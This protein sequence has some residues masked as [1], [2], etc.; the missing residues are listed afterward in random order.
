MDE[1]LD[2]I[3]ILEGTDK[4]SIGHGYLRH[5]DRILG[6]LRHAPITVLEIGVFR[7]AS[8]RMWARYFDQAKIVGVDINPECRQHADDRCDVEIGSQA[9]PQFLDDL[10]RKWQPSVIIDDGSHQA[11]HVILTFRKL[12]PH[13]RDAGIYIVEDLHLHAGPYGYKL[14]GSS[15]VAPGE[16]FLQITGLLS[17]PEETNF[18]DRLLSY[19]MDS[20]E[21]FHGGVAFRKKPVAESDPFSSRRPLVATADK[22]QLWAGFAMYIL[23]RGGDADEA[24]A[25]VRR[26]IDMEPERAGYQHQLSLILQRK[27]DP[28]GALAAAREAVRLDPGFEM[29]QARLAEL[30]AEMA[31]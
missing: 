18:Q 1:T 20:V 21:H 3:G 7:G 8:L 2:A 9:D 16:L 29:F 28:A 12:F 10:G 19:A 4:S 5:Y 11:D 26:A 23:S 31:G 25:C 24:L 27:G 17:C 13:L 15:D 22:P 14:R 6:H 30:Q